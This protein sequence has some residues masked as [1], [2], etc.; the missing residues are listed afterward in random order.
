MRRRAENIEAGGGHEIV[1]RKASYEFTMSR[2]AMKWPGE[3]QRFHPVRGANQAAKP[4]PNATEDAHTR[5]VPTTRERWA[6]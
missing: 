2:E 5:Y 6:V 1:L 3:N 4:A